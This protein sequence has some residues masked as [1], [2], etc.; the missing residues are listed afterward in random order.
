MRNTDEAY[1]QRPPDPSD[2][3]WRDEENAEED[4]EQQDP[5]RPPSPPQ[6]EANAPPPAEEITPL[7]L[8]A[9]YAG[10]VLSSMAGCLI[11]LGLTALG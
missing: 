1:P 9:H 5:S 10:L 2:V 6:P 3:S 7:R 4:P 11:R 8:S